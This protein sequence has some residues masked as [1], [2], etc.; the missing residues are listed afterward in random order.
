MAVETP[1]TVAE[2]IER[3][4]PH[5]A[6]ERIIAAPDCGFKYMP[7]EIAR[8]KLEALVKGADMARSRLGV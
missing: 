1:E 7:R 2:R 5:V 6:P 4:Y 3:A 8:G